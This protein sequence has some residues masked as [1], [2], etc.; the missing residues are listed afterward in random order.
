MR[1][2]G[3][4]FYSIDKKT[5]SNEP[6]YFFDIHKYMYNALHAKS[7]KNMAKYLMILALSNIRFFL[8]MF[9]KKNKKTI[10]AQIYHPTRPI[11][12]HLLKDANFRVVTSSLLAEKGWK[13]FFFQR[14]IPIRGSKVN[15]EKNVVLN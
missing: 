3:L 13:K 7:I 12:S 14:L 9:D 5:A 2:I 15:L 6:V 1:E 11:I 4:E 10:Y 8:D